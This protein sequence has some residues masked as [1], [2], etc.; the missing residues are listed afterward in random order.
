LHY[1]LSFSLASISSQN[2]LTCWLYSDDC[3]GLESSLRQLADRLVRLDQQQQG[4]FFFY[5]QN[6]LLLL[7]FVWTVYAPIEWDS[8]GRESECGKKESESPLKP[9]WIC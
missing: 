9:R 3:W 4:N 6:L 7:A 2:F 1:E 8:S 5:T